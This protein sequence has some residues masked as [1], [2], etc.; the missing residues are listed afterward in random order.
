MTKLTNMSL[1]ILKFR[2]FFLPHH[3]LYIDIELIWLSNHLVTQNISHTENPQKQNI[4]PHLTL[5]LEY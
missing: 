3:T 5:F 1:F 2:D 4:P